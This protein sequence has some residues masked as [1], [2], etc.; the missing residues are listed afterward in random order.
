M[1]SLKNKLL[2]TFTIVVI[3]ILLSI[4]ISPWVSHARDNYPDKEKFE[5]SKQRPDVSLTNRLFTFPIIEELAFRFPVLFI[6]TAYLSKN[7]YKNILT[8]LL[9]VSSGVIFGVLHISNGGLY[10]LFPTIITIS[11]NGI[12]LNILIL[13]GEHVSYPILAHSSIN[14]IIELIKS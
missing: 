13:K 9:V 5:E 10:L 4:A 11:L 3:S 12:L 6:F 7:K 8:T 2:F 14:F 1:Q